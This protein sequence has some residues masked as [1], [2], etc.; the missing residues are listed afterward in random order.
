MMTHGLTPRDARGGLRWRRARKSP[1]P[2]PASEFILCVVLQACQQP[3]P[4][5]SSLPVAEKFL[6]LNKTWPMLD[7]VQEG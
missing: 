5:P 3:L 2:A 7:V 4:T 6:R 1:S